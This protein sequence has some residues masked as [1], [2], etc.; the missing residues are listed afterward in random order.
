VPAAAPQK[1]FRANFLRELWLQVQSMRRDDV[2]WL[3][4]LGNCWFFFLAALLQMNL[5]VYGK[6]V[7]HLSDTQSG[8]MQAALAIGIGIGSFVAGCA[9]RGHIEYRLIPLGTIGLGITGCALAWPGMQAVPFSIWLALLGFTGGFFIVPVAALLQHRPI[10]E[11][12]GGVLAA[13]NL[14]SFVAIFAAS[15]IDYLLAT[16]LHLNPRAIFFVCGLF[17]AI[18]AIFVIQKACGRLTRPPKVLQPAVRNIVPALTKAS[19]Q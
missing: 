15:G 18:T 16:V 7:L 5:F 12:K 13:S 10:R 14:L 17:A 8:F 9:S 2:L 3:A 4:N 19:L 11:N 6:D 1:P